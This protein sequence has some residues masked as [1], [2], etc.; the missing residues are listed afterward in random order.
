M[1]LLNALWSAWYERRKIV[2]VLRGVQNDNMC[3][4]SER[5][6]YIFIGFKYIYFNTDVYDMNKFIK[7]I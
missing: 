6:K 5:F 3:W 2:V 7:I 1:S 4:F